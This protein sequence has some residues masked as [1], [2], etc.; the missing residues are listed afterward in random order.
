DDAVV[1]LWDGKQPDKVIVQL[2]AH[3]QPIR[4]VVFD[5]K[6]TLAASAGDDRV[7]RLWD[8]A[9]GEEIRRFE[10]HVG[11]T[12]GLQFMAD[13]RLLVSVGHDDT[14]R[15]LDVGTGKEQPVFQGQDGWELTYRGQQLALRVDKQMEQT[16]AIQELQNEVKQSKEENAKLRDLLKYTALRDLLQYTVLDLH[17]NYLDKESKETQELA[18]RV[19]QDDNLKQK[20]RD[21]VGRSKNNPKIALIAANALT[22]LNAA[23][24]SFAGKNLQGIHAAAKNT[25][26]NQWQGP[27]LR[28]A[29]LTKAQFTGADLRGARFDDADITGCVFTNARLAQ[30]RFTPKPGNADAVAQPKVLQGHTAAVRGVDFSPDGKHVASTGSDNMVRVW[31]A[32]SGEQ[33]KEFS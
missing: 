25:E 23:G 15:V 30:A 33:V 21:L 22:V 27:D 2:K 16:L 4:S 3:T 31:D 29:K 1:K 28:E 20:L 6:A 9:K 5:P 10:G 14:L 19:K 11:G 13:G 32:N 8:V 7:I 18:D 17:Q 26:T 24:E 12:T